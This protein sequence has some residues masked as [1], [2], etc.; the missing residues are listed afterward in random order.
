[1]SQDFEFTEQQPTG[2]PI[3]PAVPPLAKPARPAVDPLYRSPVSVLAG[4]VVILAMLGGIGYLGYDAYAKA[5]AATDTPGETTVEPSKPDPAV[6]PEAT[7]AV[8][9]A[10]VDEL[11][12][13]IKALSARLDSVEAKSSPDPKALE[14]KVDTLAKADEVTAELPARIA[15]L[16]AKVAAMSKPDPADDG[17]ADAVAKRVDDLAA[18]LDAL[19]AD[20]ATLAK[21]PAMPADAAKPVEDVNVADQAMSQAADLFKQRNYA[22]SLALFTKL[23]ADYPEDARVWYFSALANGLSTREWR[24]ET[25]RLVTKGVEKEKAGSPESSKIDAVFSGLTATTGKDWLAA[26]RSRAATR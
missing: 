10:D 13:T 7:S 17:K 15:A 22:E 2:E 14:E 1:M 9:A 3:K 21:A 26:F 11:K 20:V 23:Q 5:P 24:G 4:L 16:E 25:E 18:S 19:K 12:A 8:M 6:L